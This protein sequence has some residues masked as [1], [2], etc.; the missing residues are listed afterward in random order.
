[1]RSHRFDHYRGDVFVMVT[2]RT[3]AELAGLPDDKLAA[4]CFGEDAEQR[5]VY[6]TY[7][8]RNAHRLLNL[9][10]DGWMLDEAE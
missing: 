6:E 2:P 8:A 4:L 10:F 5:Y 9:Y 7:Q 3:R 1:M